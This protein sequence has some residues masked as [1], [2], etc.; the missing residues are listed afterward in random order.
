MTAVTRPNGK[1]ALPPDGVCWEA[2]ANNDERADGT[3]YYSVRSTGVYC[4]PSCRSRLPRRENVRF[5]TTPGEAE[6]AG[7]RACKR[8][9]PT[10]PAAE[11]L[12]AAAVARV[13]RLV[14]GS[15]E[16]PNLNALAEEAGLSRFH[17]HRKFKALIGLTPRAYAAEVR[18]RRLRKELP[19]SATVTDAIYRSGFNSSGTFHTAST[20]SLGMTPTRF[21]DGGN[22]ETI[23]FSVAASSLGSVL[24]AATDKGVCS[25]TLGDDPRALVS[26]LRKRFDRADVAEASKEFDE[27]VKK[28]IEFVEQPSIGLEV[29]LDVR[30]TAFQARVWRALCE[31]PPGSTASYTDIARRIGAPKA[32]RAVAQAC[33]SNPIAVAIPCHRVVR[34]DGGLSGYRWGVARKRALLEREAAE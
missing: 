16:M 6:K 17:F 21:R 28:V 25:V 20:Q 33:A 12:H 10:A 27:V 18:A 13:C 8:C 23:R 22:G 4:R 9:R 11:E 30:G 31:I 34:G 1:T 29:P 3:F 14:E 7:F 26:E 5:H 2:V 15:D 19:Q 24:V 32:A